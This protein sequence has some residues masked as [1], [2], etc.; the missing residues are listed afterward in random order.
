MRRNWRIARGIVSIPLIL[1]C[2][3]C[4]GIDG[5]GGLLNVPVASEE[6]PFVPFISP[7]YEYQ[8]DIP[9]GFEMEGM[10]GKLTSWSYIPPVE[11]ETETTGPIAPRIS[12]VVTDIPKGYSSR[13]LFDT[14][15]AL[16]T[17]GMNE[18][19][20]NLKNLQVVEYPKGYALMVD[21]VDKSNKYAEN[22]RFYYIYIDD[23]SYLVDISG[24]AS[25][26]KRWETYFNHVLES[27]QI[28]Q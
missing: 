9:R 16:I 13:S 14:K 1:L 15:T 5:G 10:E 8:I 12:V 24:T 11:E 18:P 19:D 4:A 23:T 7:K 27:F 2:A 17:E 28:I 21:A 26:L 6:P 20:S 3:A 22:H 25:D